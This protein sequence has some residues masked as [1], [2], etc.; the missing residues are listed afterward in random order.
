VVKSSLPRA[1]ARHSEAEASCGQ[2]RASSRASGRHQLLRVPL[3][4]RLRHSATL[5]HSPTRCPGPALCLRALSL[6]AGCWLLSIYEHG[7]SELSCVRRIGRR[8]DGM[9]QGGTLGGDRRQMSSRH[10]APR[11]AL[12][13]AGTLDGD[14]RHWSLRA[15]RHQQPSLEAPLD[16]SRSALQHQQVA[17]W[18][19]RLA[20]ECATRVPRMSTQHEGDT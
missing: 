20:Q 3:Q 15:L 19:Q 11:L 2:S 16:T 17:R 6:P 5:R 14:S 7:A 13:A 10:T 12:R 1:T 18:L 9:R 4:G 8:A